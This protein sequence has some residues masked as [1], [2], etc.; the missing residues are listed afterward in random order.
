MRLPW[1]A[2]TLPVPREHPGQSNRKIRKLS[3]WFP[4]AVKVDINT[5]ESCWFHTQPN[6]HPIHSLIHSFTGYI[7]IE[8]PPYAK[9]CS[10]HWRCP[11]EWTDK[12]S[13]RLSPV[14]PFISLG[15]W[16]SFSWTCEILSFSRAKSLCW[17]FCAPFWPS[18][19]LNI[20]RVQLKL[21]K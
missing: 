12:K 20:L 9:H 7:L 10:R 21:D 13:F 6:H 18:Q 1:G 14:Q 19:N 11:S 3:G 16:P 2:L 8:H 5:L 15:T 17:S 4:C